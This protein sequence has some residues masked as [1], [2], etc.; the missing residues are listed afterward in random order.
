M[1]DIVK[2]IEPLDKALLKCAEIIR[3]SKK[4]AVT[5]HVNPDGDAVGSAL[6][7]G[8]FLKSLGKDV[9]VALHSPVPEN[10]LFL[11]GSKDIRLYEAERDESGFLEAD[12]IFVVDLNDTKRL[13]AVG[14][15]VLKS[16]ATK[17]V[18]DHHLEPKSYADVYAVDT[19][20]SSTGEL[21]YKLIKLF[22]EYKPDK[23]VAEALYA[24][25]ETDTGGFR[26]PRTDSEVHNIIA[27]LI[28]L[29]CDPPRIYDEIYNQASLPAMKLLGE[30]LAGAEI[31]YEGKLCVLTLEAE[32]FEKCG[33]TQYD[34]EGIVEHSHELK[35]VVVGILL[36]QVP[37]KAEIRV[38]FRSKGE[39]SIRET[40]VKFGGGGHVHAAGARIY[41]K[42]MNEAK[43]EVIA[44]L[45]EIL[46]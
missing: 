30:A 8:H 32:Q 41:E 43:Q 35:G 24:A 4:I 9:F 45:G 16:G 7:M 25:I 19:G 11:D 6:A 15:A 17:A 28:D 3:E 10:F 31:Y 1:S 23:A 5:S 13:K 46:K 14:D 12:A 26:F 21:I 42:S 29:G 18:I 27:D 22:P 38:S 44:V 37:D 2:K 34:V 40:A 36:S 20:A 39:Y 33:A